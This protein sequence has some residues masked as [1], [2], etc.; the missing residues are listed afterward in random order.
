MYYSFIN[1]HFIFSTKISVNFQIF[2][3]F[4]KKFLETKKTD[5]VHVITNCPI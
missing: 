5:S 2:P 4:C 1:I 3:Y